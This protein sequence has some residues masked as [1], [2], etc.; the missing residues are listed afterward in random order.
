[1]L[2]S[3]GSEFLQ[4]DLTACRVSGCCTAIS[5]TP[6]DMSTVPKEYHNFSNVFSKSKSDK[7]APH[8][9][10]DLKINLEKGTKP[11]PGL[12]YSLSQSELLALR[13]FIDEH[14]NINVRTGKPRPLNK[15]KEESYRDL[16]KD[17]SIKMKVKTGVYR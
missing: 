4:L 2:Y 10:Y 14:I 1:M 13:E 11:P 8:C 3:P 7:L 15:V 6:V 5:N 16:S 12:I 9:P 17:Q